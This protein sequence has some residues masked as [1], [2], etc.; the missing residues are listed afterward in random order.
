MPH[1]REELEKKLRAKAEEAIRTLLE[2]LPDKADLTM[3][4]MEDLIG[5]MGQDMMRETMQEVSQHEQ[6]EPSWV[7]CQ[8]CGIEMQKRGKR[9]KRVVTKRGEIELKRQYYVCPQCGQR[10]FPPG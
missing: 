5:K 2:T 1:N 4:D 10:A 7:M 6:A 9:K 3:D 8:T